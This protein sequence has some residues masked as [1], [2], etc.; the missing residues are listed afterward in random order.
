VLDVGCWVSGLRRWW[1]GVGCSRKLQATGVS[2]VKNA[3]AKASVVI[4]FTYNT[5]VNGKPMG[6]RPGGIG[7]TAFT[8]K[9]LLS[10]QHAT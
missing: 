9:P 2:L 6:G 10:D 7:T 1:F 8:T 5:C 3:P 4:T